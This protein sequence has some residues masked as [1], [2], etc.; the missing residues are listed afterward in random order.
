MTADPP[1]SPDLDWTE[2]GSPIAR[3]FG[4]VYYADADG[5][6]ET[7]HVF[8][9]GNDLP[10]R[11]R[12]RSSFAIGELGFGVGLNL[13]TL[14]AEW[15]ADPERCDT[16]RFASVEAAPPTAD[17]IRRA[18]ARWPD[19]SEKTEALL[20]EQWPPPPGLSRRRLGPIDLELW[21]GDVADLPDAWGRARDAWFLDG[22]SPAKNPEMWRLELMK[23]LRARTAPGGGVATY[24]AA[25]WVRRNLSAAGFDIARAP[26]FGRKRE[27]L[28]G[29][30]SEDP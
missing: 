6:A 26:G 21:I 19:L 16:L 22:F 9:A 8:L 12:G 5:R 25:G 1:P 15:E 4:D 10:D 7:K 29:R 2:A 11:W 30:V 24:A 13:L 3:R 27:M 20:A 23:G 28:R 14:W 18:L 17:A